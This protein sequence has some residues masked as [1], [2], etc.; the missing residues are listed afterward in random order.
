MNQEA[1]LHVLWFFCFMVRFER[2]ALYGRI[3]MGM[4]TKMDVVNRKK[5][6]FQ[7]VGRW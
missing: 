6:P 3:S 1:G 5:G 4:G 2:L 7:G